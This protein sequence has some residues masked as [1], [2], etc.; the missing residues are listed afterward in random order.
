MTAVNDLPPTRRQMQMLR[1]AAEGWSY[2]EIATR[3][4]LSEKTVRN[5][6]YDARCYLGVPSTTAA[7]WR[8]RDQ[9]EAVDMGDAA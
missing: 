2:S 5:R 6:L 8:L 7:V 1:L 9:L 3:L 4:G